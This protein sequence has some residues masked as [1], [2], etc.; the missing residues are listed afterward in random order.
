MKHY[1]MLTGFLAVLLAIGSFGGT[2]PT[3]AATTFTV[4][5][6]ADAADASAGNGVCETAP[7]N[8]VCTLRA[9]IL[10]A[11]TLAGADTVILPAGT[12]ALSLTASGDID[13]LQDLAL[14]GAG[15]NNTFIEAAP[16]FQDRLLDVGDINRGL[17]DLTVTITGVTIRRGTSKGSG[18]G[19]ANDSTLTINDSMI[20]GN[21]ARFTSTATGGDGGG[22]YNTRVLRMNNSTISDN[23]ADD[24]GG[25]INNVGI[26]ILH[27]VTISGNRSGGDG[28]GM[29]STNSTTTE[30]NTVIT[31][32]TIASNWAGGNGGNIRNGNIFR[33]KNTLIGPSS[34]ANGRNCSSTSVSPI[35]S[36]GH[37]LESNG[38]TCNLKTAFGD[39]INVDA[40]L[41][42]L[43]PNGGPT[44]THALSMNSPAI[45]KG[46][47]SGCTATDQRGVARPQDGDRNGTAICDIGAYEH[48]PRVL[49]PLTEK[50]Y[51]P[52]STR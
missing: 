43:Y 28:G 48:I 33:M 45:D 20:T 24:D 50:F 15:A 42:P 5:S 34:S 25:G 23:V 17:I 37:N 36:D 30:S 13:I 39:L 6:T 12:Y 51:L 26:M 14:I 9:A 46:D 3:Y 47:P 49:P 10:E 40:G 29:Q 11:N 8:G 1:P 31:S 32:S 52:I 44:E 41:S 19:I 18:G 35:T 27:N 22:I 2:S 38:N 21:T 4:N 7:G 16:G